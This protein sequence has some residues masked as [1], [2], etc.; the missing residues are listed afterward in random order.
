[1]ERI[2]G[3]KLFPL[4]NHSLCQEIP[5]MFQVESLPDELP[6][7]ASHTQVLCTTNQPLF[8]CDSLQV[9]KDVYHTTSM[10]SLT[11]LVFWQLTYAEVMV[12]QDT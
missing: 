10:P 3:D 9:L 11:A 2:L 12:Y 7:H 5:P 4:I 8:L 1:M 6:S